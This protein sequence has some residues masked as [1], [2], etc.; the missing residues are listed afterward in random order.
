VSVAAAELQDSQVVE[1]SGRLDLLL[2]DR[3]T[4]PTDFL[5]VLLCQWW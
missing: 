1:V 4:M 2:R 3:R 5:D